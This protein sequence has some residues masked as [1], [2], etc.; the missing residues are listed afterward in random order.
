M[1]KRKGKYLLLSIAR[2]K[3]AKWHIVCASDDFEE[4]K[5]LADT[6]KN[7]YDVKIVRNGSYEILYEIN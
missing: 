3:N 4:L 6:C 2:R 1:I 5:R 7:R